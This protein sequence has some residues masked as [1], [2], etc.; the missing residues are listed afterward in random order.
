[1][2]HF[3]FA[4]QPDA[5]GF[6]QSPFISNT[7]DETNANQE[8]PF[9][10]PFTLVGG[11]NRIISQYDGA[12]SLHSLVKDQLFLLQQEYIEPLARMRRML[13]VDYAEGVWLDWLGE[14]VAFPR[15]L[16][17]WQAGGYP[18]FG[19]HGQTE[20]TGWD[21]APFS[22]VNPYKFYRPPLTDEIYRALLRGRGVFLRSE[23][24][25]VALEETLAAVLGST[26]SFGII[27]SPWSVKIM[28][29][30]KGTYL[31]SILRRADIQPHILPIQTGVAV[32]ISAT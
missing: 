21:D 10:V 16:G 28:I 11:E 6:D 18:M 30:G 31:P 17:E 26:Y 7:G 20:A 29:S 2:S 15:P 9:A 32:T 27:E 1:M 13:H 12:T 14:R 3:G 4:G 5:T 23:P 24:S 25:F 19:F 22:S 8:L